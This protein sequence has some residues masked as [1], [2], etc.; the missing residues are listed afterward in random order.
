LAEAG[1]A[2]GQTGTGK[3]P[4]AWGGTLLSATPRR[5]PP[6]SLITPAHLLRHV[7]SL[8]SQS[9]AEF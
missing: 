6:A 5:P 4:A 3:A 8:L 7:L 1:P 9:A 2:V